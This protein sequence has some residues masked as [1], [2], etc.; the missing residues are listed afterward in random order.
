MRRRVP[1]WKRLAVAAIVLVAGIRA[2]AAEVP[3]ATAT[4]VSTRVPLVHTAQF[5]PLDAGGRIVGAGQP[6][7]QVEA[8]L[9]SL[10]QSLKP[11]GRSLKDAI[12]FNVYAADDS[13]IDVLRAALAAR[14]GGA[15]PVMTYVVGKLPVADALVAIDAVVTGI[16]SRDG[17]AVMLRREAQVAGAP[18]GAHL[19][20][21]PAGRHVYISGQA[22]PR[23]N[24]MAAATQRT[25]EMLRGTLDHLG[26]KLSDVVQVK[27]FLGPMS[28]V[29][30]AE[31]EIVKF[32]GAQT[33]P[34]LVFVEWIS[35]LPIEIELVVAGGP[36]PK[37]SADPIEY[38]TPPGERANPVFCRVTRINGPE[39]LYI[40]GLYGDSANDGAAENEEIFRSLQSTLSENGSD[41]RHMAKATYYV[42]TKAA[43][44]ELGEI[45]KK[46]YDPKRPPAASKAQVVGTGKPGRTI[47][48]DMI[49]VPKSR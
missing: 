40:G 12:K 2:G 36:A 24:D 44:D 10:E 43:T 22:A 32:F 16:A 9:S 37:N 14:R 46:L 39:V 34:S 48:L 42:V 27:S 38:I 5:L 7:A 13:T 3:Q 49:A 4:L 41:I 26:L 11:L 35:D 6:R 20:I 21:L 31:R 30:E 29:K 23:G 15:N 45:R 25:L 19:A 8:V 17:S 47:T 18:A 33:T 1:L 28:Q